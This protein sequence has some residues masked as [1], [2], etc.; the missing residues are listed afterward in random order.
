MSGGRKVKSIWLLMA[1]LIVAL[2]VT[3]FLITDKKRNAKKYS[4][5]DLTVWE[6]VGFVPEGNPVETASGI[7]A[8]Y[9]ENGLLIYDVYLPVEEA[10]SIKLVCDKKIEVT[11][12][13]ATYKNGD[14]FTV[15]FFEKIS[16]RI[17]IPDVGTEAADFRFITFQHP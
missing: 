16:G 10:D 5:Y 12:D 13:N 9:D 3:L 1:V 17:K 2:S 7:Y 6:S 15:P 11:I 8:H 4:D 14:T